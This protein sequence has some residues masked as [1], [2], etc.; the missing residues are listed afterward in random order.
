MARK[1]PEVCSG[2]RGDD[3]GSCKSERQQVIAGLLDGLG[4]CALVFGGEAGVFAREDFARVGDEGLHRWWF[5]RS[6]SFEKDFDEMERSAE[7]STY[8]PVANVACD[9]G[10]W[11]VLVA[12]LDRAAVS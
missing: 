9:L 7:L 4:D 1:R 8:K 11:H 10:K 2:L 5:V 3:L 12:Q 6:C